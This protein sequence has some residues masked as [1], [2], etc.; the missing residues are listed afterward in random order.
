MCSYVV[1]THCEAAET[2][3]SAFFACIVVYRHELERELGLERA[4]LG[5]LLGLR[6][7][8]LNLHGGTKVG[9]CTDVW[10]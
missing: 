7:V 4:D 1:Y 3:K 5:S 2:T 9:L 8:I 6:V 10:T